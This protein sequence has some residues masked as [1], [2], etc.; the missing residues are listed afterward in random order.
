[1]LGFDQGTDRRKPVR[2]LTRDQFLKIFG[3]SSGAFDA[4]QRAGHVALAFGTPSPAMPGRYCDLDLTALAIAEALAPSLGRPIATTIVLGFFNQWVAAVGQ[5]DADPARDYFFAIGGFGWGDDKKRFRELLVTHGASEQ[6]MTDL[7]G[8]R[9]VIAVNI[10]QILARLR[11]KARAAGIDLS[12]PF[13]F[14]PEHERYSQIIAEFQQ[15]R[16][17]RLARLRRT[18]KETRHP[19]AMS[20]RNIRAVEK[21]GDA[22]VQPVA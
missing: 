20:R 5:A 11:D 3:L 4:Q 19:Q 15:E 16:D 14:P 1:M 21:L 6:I 2:S 9:S 13:F 7:H 17:A 8:A 12:Q 10:T 18:N 22:R